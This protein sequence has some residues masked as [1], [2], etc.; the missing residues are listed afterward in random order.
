MR[1]LVSLDLITSVGHKDVVTPLS[2]PPAPYLRHRRNLLALGLAILALALQ[3]LVPAGFMVAHKAQDQLFAITL[4][5]S[6]GNVAAFIDQDGAIVTAPQ[7][8]D[9]PDE[10]DH[11]GKNPCAFASHSAAVVV[12]LLAAVETPERVRDVA[13]PTAL[14]Y[15]APGLGLAAPPPPKTGPPIQA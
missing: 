12:P 2:R 4:C 9:L 11:T 8:G 7:H 5:T 14:A 10:T 15:V 13:Q 6:D 1:Q 3:G